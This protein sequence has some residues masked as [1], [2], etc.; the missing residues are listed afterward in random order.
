MVIRLC[1]SVIRFAPSTHGYSDVQMD[2]TYGMSAQPTSASREKGLIA[3]T[4]CSYQ[5]SMACLPSLLAA[6]LDSKG[7]PFRKCGQLGLNIQHA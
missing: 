7:P 5:A 1:K 4:F 2:L 6:F 3:S